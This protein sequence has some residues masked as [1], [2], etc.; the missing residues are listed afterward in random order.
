M[1]GGKKEKRLPPRASLVQRVSLEEKKEKKKEEGGGRLD[2]GRREEGSNLSKPFSAIENS[3]P[4][5][6]FSSIFN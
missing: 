4:E 1:G 5:P 2:R 3:M 6:P